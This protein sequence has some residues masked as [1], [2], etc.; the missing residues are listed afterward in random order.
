[1]SLGSAF[2]FFTSAV[3]FLFLSLSFFFVCF[4]FFLFFLVSPC[5]FS[6]PHFFV[7]FGFEGLS[8]TV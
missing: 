5:P 2:R 4:V 1:M 8:L 7:W 6:F 3:Y